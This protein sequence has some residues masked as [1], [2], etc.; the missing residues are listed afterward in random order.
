MYRP[1]NPQFYLLVVEVVAGLECLG[2]GLP[3]RLAAVAV[4]FVQAAGLPPEA[5][6]LAL[7]AVPVYYLEDI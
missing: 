5:D 6:R 3:V 2:L 7:P 4:G 1:Q